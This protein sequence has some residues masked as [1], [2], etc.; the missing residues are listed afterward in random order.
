MTKDGDIRSQ[1]FEWLCGLV[2]ADEPDH[3]YFILMDKLHQ[4]EFFSAIPRDENRASYG[5]DLRSEFA[6]GDR[7]VEMSLIGPVSVLE[8]LVALA[9]SMA[10]I[11]WSPE[12][13]DK[14][15]ECF[16]EMIS[17]LGLDQLDDDNYFEAGGRY[18]VPETLDRLLYRSYKRNGSGGLFPVRKNRRD[19][20]KI[21]L[22]VQMQEYIEE[23]YKY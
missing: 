15:P 22:W 18:L 10:D 12:E 6:D 5:A 11:L 16:W 1:Y 19:Q 2:R 21:E 23:N 3:S 14:T 20:R 4:K 7:A 9:A 13:E 17:N 8:V